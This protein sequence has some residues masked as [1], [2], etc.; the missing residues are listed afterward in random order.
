[1]NTIEF[2]LCSCVTYICVKNAIKM[3]DVF[4]SV[5]YTQFQVYL[6]VIMHVIVNG[7]K[8]KYKV[9]ECLFQCT[10]HI[11]NVCASETFIFMSCTNTFLSNQILIFL[12]D[13]MEGYICDT[14]HT[15]THCLNWEYFTHLTLG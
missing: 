13:K 3:T 15:H 11:P 4:G 10:A 14:E 1:M 5:Q 2:E 12:I 6:R 9:S 7:N 8:H